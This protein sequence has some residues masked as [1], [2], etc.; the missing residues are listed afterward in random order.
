MR[1]RRSS[2]RHK[3]HKMEI[4]T[5]KQLE[6]HNITQLETIQ[7]LIA[8]IVFE[9][10]LPITITKGDRVCTTDK[11]AGRDVLVLLRPATS[12]LGGKLVVDC[13]DNPTGLDII[14]IVLSPRFENYTLDAIVTRDNTGMTIHPVYNWDEL[15]EDYINHTNYYANEFDKFMSD[16]SEDE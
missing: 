15:L 8:P 3:L 6:I 1:L 7:S 9:G 5:M 14:T 4:K 12:K 10:E 11:Y 2:A 13:T 16:E